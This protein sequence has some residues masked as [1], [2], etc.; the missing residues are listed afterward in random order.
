MLPINPSQRSQ[1]QSSPNVHRVEAAQIDLVNLQFEKP[2]AI[3]AQLTQ[4]V[5]GSNNGLA[6]VSQLL[7]QMT[8]IT[9]GTPAERRSQQL[10][11]L[12][13]NGM[14]AIAAAIST[15]LKPAPAPAKDTLAGAPARASSVAAAPSAPKAPAQVAP[16][17][18]VAPQTAPVVKASPQATAPQ[19][20]QDVATASAPS[21]AAAESPVAAS[22]IDISKYLTAAERSET[23]AQK[24]GLAAANASHRA[25][26]D[27]E[28]LRAHGSLANPT[29]N[30]EFRKLFHAIS[31]FAAEQSDALDEF[32]DPIAQKAV[33]AF[34]FTQAEL[35]RLNGDVLAPASLF[36]EVV[37]LDSSLESL[38]NPRTALMLAK[39]GRIQSAADC[40]VFVLK[41]TPD[42]PHALAALAEVSLAKGNPKRA[43]TLAE[44]S[45]E[46]LPTYEARELLHR[47]GISVVND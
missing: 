7:D 2:A 15:W 30:P 8:G 24:V 10:D 22:A 29:A 17:A 28:R 37:Q 40:A 39:A 25:L 31:D 21:A 14:D 9:Q 13:A 5:N 11:S 33:A 16:T 38:V 43:Q 34:G 19:L 4:Y 26:A 44:A 3:A 18:P 20:P 32:R 12:R 27:A 23:V 1:T 42:S 36:Q 6:F 46:S 47:L 35:Q 41:Q 45:W